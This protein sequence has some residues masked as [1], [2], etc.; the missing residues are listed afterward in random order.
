MEDI[1]TARPMQVPG[2]DVL[3]L[4]LQTTEALAELESQLEDGDKFRQLVN[5]N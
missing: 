1:V 2:E 5:H 4:P 3:I